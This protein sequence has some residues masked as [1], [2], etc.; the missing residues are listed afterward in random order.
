L[1][2]VTREAMDPTTTFL[3]CARCGQPTRPFHE[4]VIEGELEMP[5]ELPFTAR[6]AYKCTKCDR[7]FCAICCH[8]ADL[9]KE[10]LQP[11]R[12]SLPVEVI[13]SHPKAACPECRARVRP[14][15]TI[16]AESDAKPADDE[17]K[18][19]T[20]GQRVLTAFF[21]ILMLSIGVI[22]VMG[23]A[24]IKGVLMCGVGGSLL[25]AAVFSK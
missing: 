16:D 15:D 3:T 9:V 13:G 5:A 17:N 11:G 20:L 19:W 24:W 22:W 12:F 4:S 10:M 21:A 18:S 1:N 23:G 25:F 8:P 7:I 14:C 2:P 6:L